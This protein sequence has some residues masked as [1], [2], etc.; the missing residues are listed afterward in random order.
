VGDELGVAQ[1]VSTACASRISPP[2]R[3]PR[4]RDRRHDVPALRRV[5]RPRQSEGLHQVPEVRVQVRLQRVV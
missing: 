2:Q 3:A 1:T 5:E 4:R